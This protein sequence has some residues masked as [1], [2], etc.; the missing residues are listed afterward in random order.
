[1]DKG[2]FD[3]LI[4][5]KYILKIK[6]GWRYYVGNYYGLE[7]TYNMPSK[8]QKIA[9]IVVFKAFRCLF[10]SGM[11]CVSDNVLVELQ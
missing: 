6:I 1:L 4:N 11:T 8:D 2:K 10:S 7:M 9:F 3:I 5:I